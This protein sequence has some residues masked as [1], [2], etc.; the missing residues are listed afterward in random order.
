MPRSK[1]GVPA[2]R[3]G[4]EAPEAPAGAPEPRTAPA[5]SNRAMTRGKGKDP[6]PA[7]PPPPPPAPAEGAPPRVDP[8][9]SVEAA[10]PGPVVAAVGEGS[11][12]DGHHRVHYFKCASSSR[13][14]PLQ[15]LGNPMFLPQLCV[16]YN[17]VA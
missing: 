17:F 5:A 7:A 16:S 15:P 14:L 13:S 11:Q 10:G 3:L 1:A 2:P 4:A 8:G 6:V 12:S 9:T